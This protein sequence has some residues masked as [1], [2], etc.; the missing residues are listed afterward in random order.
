MTARPTTRALLAAACCASAFLA[1]PASSKEFDSSSFFFLPVP[2]FMP[3][4]DC[5]TVVVVDSVLDD[6]F[7]R[8]GTGGCIAWQ[9]DSGGVFLV[10]GL[11]NFAVGDRV[12]VT[13]DI[14]LWCLTTCRAGAIENSAI[15]A[16]E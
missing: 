16:C 10:G 1:S 5:G 6:P 4:A 9:A 13:G 15:S 14:C 11:E 2:F 3:I 12:F 7:I 8:D